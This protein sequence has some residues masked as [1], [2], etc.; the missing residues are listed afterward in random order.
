MTDLDEGDAQRADQAGGPQQHPNG[1]S[2]SSGSG[3]EQQDGA[4]AFM[5]REGEGAGAY[6]RRVFQRVFCEDI[7]SVLQM[8]VRAAPPPGGAPIGVCQRPDMPAHRVLLC[9]TCRV[10]RHPL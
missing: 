7:R 1:G 10:W 6:A 4:S 5:R 2:S 3:A 9:M 8:E